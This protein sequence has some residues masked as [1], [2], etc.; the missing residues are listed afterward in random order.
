MTTFAALLDRELRADGAR[1]LVTFYDHE[2]DER[3]ELSVAT[4]AT[5]VA[6]TAS[7]LQSELD[8]E[9]GASI[10]VD[11]PTHWLGPIALGAA[12]SIGAC[13]RSAGEDRTDQRDTEADLVF[14]GGDR[15]SAWLGRHDL[16]V[17]SALHPLGLRFPEPPPGVVDLGVEVWGQPDAFSP[18]DPPTAA[19]P[20]CD[21]LDQAGLWRQAQGRLA[22]GARL[23][24][25]ANPVEPD[26]LRDFAA[27]LACGGSLVLVA[28]PDQA[29]LPHLRSVERVTDQNDRL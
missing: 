28:H 6:K 5:W 27:V 1:P 2:T 8:I 22:R 21:D 17:A 9:R 11:L 7:L 16:I 25:A 10:R 3:T 26:G 18:W 12:W 15:L 4:Y 29:R 19:D 14:T 20:A 23:L 13:V 24:T